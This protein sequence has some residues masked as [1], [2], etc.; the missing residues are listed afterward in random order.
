[1]FEVDQLVSNDVIAS[2][3]ILY[4]LYLNPGFQVM[5]LSPTRDLQ[6]M[7]EKCDCSLH[8]THD[9]A[10]SMMPELLSVCCVYSAVIAVKERT[11]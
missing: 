7:T 5:P 2:K 1:M 3:Y 8:H 9:T 10:V 4:L 11:V 6:Y